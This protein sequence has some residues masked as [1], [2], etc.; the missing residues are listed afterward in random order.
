VR[1]SDYDHR[2]ILDI[3][4]RY[5]EI[6][7]PARLGRL[8]GACALQGRSTTLAKGMGLDGS[9]RCCVKCARADE[10]LCKLLVTGRKRELELKT[11]CK[12]RRP[13]PY[14]DA[15]KLVPSHADDQ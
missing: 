15:S 7:S 3:V 13:L 2:P 11:D 6:H 9:V 1:D 10:E 4:R 5:K 14:C 12:C 8:S